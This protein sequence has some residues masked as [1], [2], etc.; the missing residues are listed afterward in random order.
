MRSE[1]ERERRILL[2]RLWSD[3]TGVPDTDRSPLT[4]NLF[5]LCIEASAPDFSP[6]VMAEAVHELGVDLDLFIVRLAAEEGQDG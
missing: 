1:I 4:Q 5:D 3:V 2:A 6:H